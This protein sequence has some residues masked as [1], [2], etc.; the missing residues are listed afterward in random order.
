MLSKNKCRQ[1]SV[2]HSLIIAI[3]A[4]EVEKVIVGRMPGK[5]V[6]EIPSQQ[7]SRCGGICLLF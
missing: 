5:R 7:K 4:S 6:S 1:E 3:Q 2:A